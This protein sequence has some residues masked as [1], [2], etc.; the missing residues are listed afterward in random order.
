MPSD[1]STRG[2]R[3]RPEG[4]AQGVG[5][6][7]SELMSSV[8]N[9]T[10][11]KELLVRQAGD[12]NI[13]I[14]NNSIS[15]RF[16]EGGRLRPRHRR[17]AA[18]ACQLCR[19]RKTKCDN[20]RPS[21]GY[22]LFQGAQCI[23]TDKISS[24]NTTSPLSLP[25]ESASQSEVSNAVLLEHIRHL[26]NLVEEIHSDPTLRT[27]HE[28]QPT[29]PG[30]YLPPSTEPLKG[31]DQT[32][33]DEAGPISGSAFTPDGF[34]KLEVTELAARTSSCESI[35]RWPSL[36]SDGQFEDITSFALQS[37]LNTEL[38]VESVLANA[39]FAIQED[40]IWPLCRKFL[41]LIHVKNPILEVAEFKRYAREAAECGP[42]W[43][44]RGCL[45]V[46]T[47]LLPR[48]EFR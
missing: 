40:K 28:L 16:Q 3:I 9:P 18:T 25:E 8:P 14:T 15:P 31:V 17:R 6:N 44:G 24:L 10:S 42:S 47:V 5:D 7:V 23:Y 48:T 1:T 36:H 4:R 38:P 27:Q 32:I 22:C 33:D 11:P 30:N 46:S 43:D 26:T 12:L 41:V 34:G 37:T 39:R 20:G 13:R 19:I 2:T 35:L 29:Y 21:C 45:V